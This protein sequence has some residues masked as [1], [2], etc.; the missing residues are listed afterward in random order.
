MD[1]MEIRGRNWVRTV[2]VWY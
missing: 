1:L 2:W